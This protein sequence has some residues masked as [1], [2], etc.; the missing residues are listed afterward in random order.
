PV[1]GEADAVTF[2]PDSELVAARH[3]HTITLWRVADGKA[4]ATLPAAD[5]GLCGLAFS[6]VDP[7]LATCLRNG[8]IQLTH[9]P[10][11]KVL[12]TLA[13]DPNATLDITFSPD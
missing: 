7:V 12:A 1:A 2:S 6:P 10:D 8:N 3:D 11:G 4:I 9:T 5:P 13:N